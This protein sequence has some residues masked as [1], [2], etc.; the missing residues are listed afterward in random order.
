MMVMMAV[1][2]MGVLVL[3]LVRM[4]VLMVVLV[5]V[6]M[7]VFVSLSVVVMAMAVIVAVIVAVGTMVV[8]VPSLAKEV[9]MVM[10]SLAAKTLF[11]HPQTDNKD[12][13]GGEQS[14]PVMEIAV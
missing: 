1:G 14:Q 3:V 11:E 7:S 5:V 12:G 10:A 2:M 8:M 13:G 9:D 4:L 6:A